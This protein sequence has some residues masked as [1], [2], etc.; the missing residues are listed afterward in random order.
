MTRRSALIGF[1]EAELGFVVAAVVAFTAAAEMPGLKQRE[2]KLV[3]ASPVSAM[4]STPV[5]P[6]MLLTRPA[7]VAEKNELG[8]N[9][10][11]KARPAWASDVLR[12]GCSEVE[13]KQL[14]RVPIDVIDVD[15][16]NRYSVGGAA[17]S[18]RQLDQLLAPYESEA[19]ENACRYTLQ[20]RPGRN[21]AARDLLEAEDPFQG[22]FYREH[23]LR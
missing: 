2:A 3:I 17:M 9:G 11:G 6:E 5:A 15:G 19:R 13:D 12:R 21:I 14:E 18:L 4:Q 1:T 20:F 7:I 23:R 22:R 10:S 8:Q 16:V